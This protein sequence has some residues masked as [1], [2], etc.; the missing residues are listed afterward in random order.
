MQEQQSWCG[1]DLAGAPVWLVNDVVRYQLAFGA[2]T[3][4]LHLSEHRARGA[5]APPISVMTLA[6]FTRPA[7]MG[8]GDVLTIARLAPAALNKTCDLVA[9][10]RTIKPPYF[11]HE[12]RNK[13]AG[14]C[15]RA[16][17]AV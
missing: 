14:V 10:T 1:G 2:T 16:Q 7:A 6:I 8:A 5:C 11:L 4:E 13:L 3:R 15:G 9:T 12:D 17:S